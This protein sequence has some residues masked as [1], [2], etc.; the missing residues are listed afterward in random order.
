MKSIGRMTI[1]LVYLA[2]CGRPTPPQSFMPPQTSDGSAATAN[3]YIAGWDDMGMW[4]PNA[5]QIA[6]FRD[7]F[8]AAHA[9]LR[10]ALSHS[11]YS[12]RMRAAYVI[13][14]IGDAAKSA[15]EDLLDRLTIE[16][17]ETIRMYVVDALNTIGY[18]TVMTVAALTKRFDALDA[19]NVPP[20]LDHSYAE[21]DEKITIA[22]ALYT[23]VDAELK[24]Q[25]YTFVT[26]WLDPP[27]KDLAGDLL[28]GY[29]DRRWIAVNSLE[30]MPGAT[31][32]IPKLESLQAEPDAK[33]WVDVHV[34]RVLAVLRKNAR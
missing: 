7:N 16:P 20:S 30:R 11:D 19:K 18:D 5:K 26:Q 10:D 12:V 1:F 6:F 4:L 28:D 24:P 25:Y 9:S 31:D 17:N 23:M 27:D 21:V 29:W 2:G 22:S 33:P 34:P 8:E 14:E 15:G 32:A 3:E 13:G